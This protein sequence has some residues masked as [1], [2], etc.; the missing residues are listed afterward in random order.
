[1]EKT[2]IFIKKLT[3]NIINGND[4]EQLLFLK[5]YPIFK[6]NLNIFE[7]WNDIYM[8]AKKINANRDKIINFI[9]LALYHNLIEYKTRD[10]FELVKVMH[11]A[12]EEETY[13]KRIKTNV[14]NGRSTRG[15]EKN[16]LINM[17]NKKNK[18]NITYDM[19]NFTPH[20]IAVELTAR[21]I[22]LIK[23][24][25]YH[26]LIYISHHDNLKFNENDPQHGLKIIDDFHKLSY[27]VPTMILLKDNTNISRLKTIKYL[28]KICSE[29][30]HLH[31]Y[32]S[33]FAIVAGL[34]NLA[35]QKM[36][37]LWKPG[38]THYETFNELCD[39]ISPL[40]NFGKYRTTIKK[41]IKNNYVQYFG[42]VLFDMKHT[43]EKE[44]YDIDNQDFNWNVCHKIIDTINNFKDINIDDKIK[45]N[46]R[47]CDWFSSFV[48]CDDDDKLYDIAMEIINER[49]KT[50]LS[51]HSDAGSP[52]KT[53]NKLN[54]GN[55]IHKHSLSDGSD[56]EH[57]SPTKFAEH[58][59]TFSHDENRN[60]HLQRTKSHKKV[61][62]SPMPP[63]DMTSLLERS[64]DGDSP[65]IIV[66]ESPRTPNDEKSVKINVHSTNDDAFLEYISDN[67]AS[68]DKNSVKFKKR[69]FR[70]RSLSPSSIG[71]IK[72]NEFEKDMAN[73]KQVTL[74]T[75]K[76]VKIWLKLLGM[77]AYMEAFVRE[78]IYGQ[79]LLE[80]TE[81]HLKNDLG[82]SILGHRLL[83]LKSI[84]TLRTKNFD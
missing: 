2:Q 22:M 67:Y 76:H 63:I 38:T 20:E 30:K 65:R 83:I 82:V 62:S 34:N 61:S 52:I 8:G 84:E 54:I 29:L 4:K 13:I 56:S 9:T 41:L 27:M 70:R 60:V 57:A 39:F 3:D 80:L 44:L 14:I 43:L 12:G 21:T 18:E 78:E 32:N 74:W 26:E 50:D 6:E 68:D 64:N 15:I 28:L 73:S 58:R 45:N 47:I 23:N 66:T 81:N 25:S 10:I 36:T 37:Q 53:K 1:M 16:Q 69:I 48:V 75:E 33:L 79:V 5:I 49:K 31:N 40:E 59:R 19:R 46:D 42:T 7:A 11:D 51:P 77:E 17:I 24:M 71:E 55:I 72:I 35:V